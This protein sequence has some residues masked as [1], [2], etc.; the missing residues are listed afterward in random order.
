LTQIDAALL[1]DVLSDIK[2]QRNVPMVVL[3]EVAVDPSGAVTA[4]ADGCCKFTVAY[5]RP[6]FFNSPLGPC[7]NGISMLYIY[8]VCC[9]NKS[10][11][12]EI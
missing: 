3:L 11:L 5:T 6:S 12:F 2:Q 7:V 10:Y 4:G 8:N 9:Y 1:S